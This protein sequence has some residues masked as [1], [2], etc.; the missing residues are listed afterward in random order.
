MERVLVGHLVD[1]SGTSAVGVKAA[2]MVDGTAVSRGVILADW[3]VDLTA[4]E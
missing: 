1:L 4:A 3:K 2:T